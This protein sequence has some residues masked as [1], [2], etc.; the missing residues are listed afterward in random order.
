LFQA[1][2][3][4]GYMNSNISISSTSS[5]AAILRHQLPARN[6][7]NNRNT[8]AAPDPN[9]SSPAATPPAGAPGGVNQAVGGPPATINSISRSAVPPSNSSAPPAAANTPPTAPNT[10]LATQ[11]AQQTATAQANAANAKAVQS[12]SSTINSVLD[13]TV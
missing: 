7:A 4:T 9:A 5:A 13:I 10:N 11:V 3:Y 1:L 6:V 12:G 2:R 8:G